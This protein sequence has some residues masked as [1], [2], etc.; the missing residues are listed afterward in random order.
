MNNKTLTLFLIILCFCCRNNEKRI[1]KDQIGEY[2]LGQKLNHKFNKNIFDIKV[3]KNNII[4]SILTKDMQYK[5]IEGFGV[6]TDLDTI[7]KQSLKYEEKNLNISKGNTNIGKFGNILIYN[8]V[9]F[10]DDNE[11]NIIDFVW[12]EKK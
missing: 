4:I 10:V 7:K 11:D 3:D 9:V 8:E 1:N 2:I 12:I 5:T 6:G